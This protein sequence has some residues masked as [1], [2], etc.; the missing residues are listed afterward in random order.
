MLSE[1][2]SMHSL[3]DLIQEVAPHWHDIGVQLGL[4]QRDL[5]IVETDHS[6]SCVLRCLKTFK[7]FLESNNPTWEEVLRSVRAVNLITLAER[8]EYQLPG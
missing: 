3:R 1:R 8:V 2:P 6:N 4:A 7:K 5:A